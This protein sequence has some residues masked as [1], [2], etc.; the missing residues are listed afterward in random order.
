M[1]A[2]TALEEDELS[3]AER[4]RRKVRDAIVEAAEAI[5]A[6]EG[7]AGISMRRIAE[8]ID[9]SP[10]ALYKYFNSKEALFDEIRE[11]FF[12]RLYG[13]MVAVA[14]TV[15]EGPLVC[16]Q[17]LRAY[18]ETG[19]EQPAHYRLAFSSWF[20]S[21]FEDRQDSF[22][23]A[24]S[25]RL[26]LM[27]EKGV[28]DGWF[29]PC[30]TYLASLFVWSGAHGL[31]MLAVTIPDFPH[32]KD[33]CAHLSLDDVIAFHAEATARGLATPKLHAWLDAKK[34]KK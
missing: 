12:E 5:F 31:T 15:T 4:R 30:D 26:D 24:A 6:E 19:L 7:E 11:Q 33:K 8:R 27:I 16:E 34:A 3:P 14:E 1:T 9:Y 2:E 22:G 20:E 29:A 28:A 25:E 18:V 23:Y 13:R 32:G 10:A 21:N 17:C